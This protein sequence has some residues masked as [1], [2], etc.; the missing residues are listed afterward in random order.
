L[1]RRLGGLQSQ[2]GRGGEE[3]NPQPLPGIEPPIIQPVTQ[4]HTAELYPPERYYHYST[5]IANQLRAN[6][7][8]FINVHIYHILQCFQHTSLLKLTKFV[9]TFYL[10]IYHTSI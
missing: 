8:S 6:E 3:K 4:H 9:F 5:D 7:A 2:S 10:S 1:D